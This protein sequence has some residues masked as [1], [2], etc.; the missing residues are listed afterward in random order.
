VV[1]ENFPDTAFWNAE[2]VT[3][4]NGRATVTVPLPDTLTTWQVDLRGLTADT[5]VGQA[6]SQVITSKDLLVRPVTPRFFVTG[7]HTQLAAIVQNNTGNPLEAE[8]ALQATGFT[9]DDPATAAQTVSVP[10]NGRTRVEWWGTAA[11]VDN[12]DL[13]F[14]ATA[15]DLQDITRPALG[16]LP[17]PHY[18]A[19]QTFATSG[20]LDEGDSRQELVSLP[21][22]FD[23]QGGS[24]TSSWRLPATAMLNALKS[25]ES[26]RTTARSKRSHVSP[27]LE[28][29]RVL[30]ELALNHELIRP[31]AH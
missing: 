24:L 2:V 17:V 1:R 15:G 16:A 4:A 13:V 3:D 31:G 23:P 29:Y 28:T 6:Q 7:D 8:A 26:F 22:S 30:Q 27:N 21:R 12:V 18:T 25:L 19:P 14:S 9:L 20:I 10:A 11:D 5:R